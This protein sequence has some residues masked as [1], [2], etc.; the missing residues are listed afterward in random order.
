MIQMADSSASKCLVPSYCDGPKVN[1]ILSWDRKDARGADC[2]LMS[3]CTFS[4]GLNSFL[5]VRPEEYGAS[6]FAVSFPHVPFV[7]ELGVARV[8]GLSSGLLLFPRPGDGVL[9]D[10]TFRRSPRRLT[11]VQVPHPRQG[12]PPTREQ[13]RHAKCKEARKGTDLLHALV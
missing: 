4:I 11:S 6:R 8:V 13:G 9:R 5:A 2:G 1:A 10:P 12:R 3:A 7:R